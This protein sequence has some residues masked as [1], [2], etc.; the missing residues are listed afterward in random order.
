MN[1]WNIESCPAHPA[2]ILSDLRTSNLGK[3]FAIVAM[4]IKFNQS[5][6]SKFIQLL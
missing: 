6:V 1:T 2:E 3:I 4:F 5:L